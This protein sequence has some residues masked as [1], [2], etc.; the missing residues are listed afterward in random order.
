M[1]R[2]GTPAG[3]PAGRMARHRLTYPA[4][5][6][7]SSA[8]MSGR[9][10]R[11]WSDTQ[12]RGERRTRSERTL[13]RH[14]CRDRPRRRGRLCARTSVERGE[15]KVAVM[16]R[17]GR[18]LLVGVLVLPGLGLPAPAPAAAAPVT[19][20]LSAGP[21]G[22]VAADP[23]GPTYEAGAIVTLTATANPGYIFIG[24]TID[25]AVGGWANPR[26]LV[27]DTD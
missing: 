17:L 7:Y 24:W 13:V 5:M 21:G 14:R 2:S 22:S 3:C 6:S 25:G 18:F 20:T 9:Q 11:P 8:G 19:L 4:L 23:P 15:G 12:H 1:L 26:K 16:A 10:Y 27:L